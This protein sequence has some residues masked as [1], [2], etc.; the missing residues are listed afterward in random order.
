MSCNRTGNLIAACS[1]ATAGLTRLN[2]KISHTTGLLLQKL[3]RGAQQAGQIG[4]K[5]TV[6]VDQVTNQA[7][8]LVSPATALL[9]RRQTGPALKKAT[10]S[11]NAAAGGLSGKRAGGS[12][13]VINTAVSGGVMAAAALFPPVRTGLKVARLADGVTAGLGA[14][15]A[16]ATMIAEAGE[17]TREKRR[18]IFFKS[19]QQVA[20]WKSGLTPLINK[21]D[22]I[23]TLNKD[24][25]LSTDGVMFETGGKAWHRGTSVVKMPAGKRTI[26]H[27][28]SLNAMAG[29]YYFE[30][31]LSA[32]QAV[33]VASGQVDHETIPGYVGRITPAES[34]CPALA[35]S[36]RLL[37]LTVKS[38]VT[39]EWNEGV[40]NRR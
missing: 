9:T 36:K 35:N 27:L 11:A 28:Q 2:S 8:E 21:R 3:N 25:V 14:A 10:V 15:V 4:R 19:T 24:N 39:P 7:G 17:V 30:R 6:R 20:L 38:N 26:T 37:L 33:G 40:K 12:R 13:R 16:S 1:P 22:V 31:S 5:L 34:L 32:E 29:H 23:G 18:L